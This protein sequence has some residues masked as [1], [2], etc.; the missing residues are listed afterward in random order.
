MSLT[1]LGTSSNQALFVLLRLAYFTSNNILKI[2][3]CG[4]LCTNVLAFLGGAPRGIWSSP[5]DRI[6][7]TDAVHLSHSCSNGSSFIH[8]ARPGLEPASSAPKILPIPVHHSGNCR[9]RFL[10][11]KNI[12]LCGGP[13]SASSVHGPQGFSTV[14]VVFLKRAGR[15]TAT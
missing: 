3:L 1:V 6:Q 12:P 11:L 7:A 2:Q 15:A 14:C 5:R 8:C 10:R 9:P 13:Y 4:S